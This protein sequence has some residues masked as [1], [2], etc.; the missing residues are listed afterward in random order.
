MRKPMWSCNEFGEHGFVFIGADLEL[1]AGGML[2]LRQAVHPFDL[3]EDPQLF[4]RIIAEMTQVMGRASSQ[5][6]SASRA[7]AFGG[8]CGEA[9]SG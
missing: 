5:P 9:S 1:S 6:V 3:D 8:G 2:G 7:G 4:A